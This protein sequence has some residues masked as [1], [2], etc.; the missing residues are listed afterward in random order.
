MRRTERDTHTPALHSAITADL[1][2]SLLRGQRRRGPSDLIKTSNKPL[3]QDEPKESRQPQEPTLDG[4]ALRQNVV[5]FQDLAALE[6]LSSENAR[7]ELQ[8]S[9]GAYQ[10]VSRGGSTSLRRSWRRDRDPRVGTAPPDQ[11]NVEVAEPQHVTG[12]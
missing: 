11:G 12:K 6:S 8:A 9:R 2:E 3:V 7:V 1:D 10:E 4:K 5:Q